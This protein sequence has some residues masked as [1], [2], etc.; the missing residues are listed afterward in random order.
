MASFYGGQ[1]LMTRK[2]WRVQGEL[3]DDRGPK[4]SRKTYIF[5][6]T[7]QSQVNTDRLPWLLLLNG[8]EI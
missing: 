4:K 3:F 1:C 5:R 2:I 6:V 8:S 7:T